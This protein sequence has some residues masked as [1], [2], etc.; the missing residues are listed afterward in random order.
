MGR[1]LGFTA[2]TIVCSTTA[3]LGQPGMPTPMEGRYD[4]DLSET[5]QLDRAQSAVNKQ[6]EQVKAYVADRQWNEAVDALIHLM[7]NSGNKLYGVTDKRYVSVREYCHLQLA[8]LP[9]EARMIYR[10]R[11]DA[12]AKKWYE[13]GAALHDGRRLMDVVDRAFTSSWGDKALRALGD[14]ALESGDYA[15]A[16]SCWE[17]IFPVEPPKEAPR[18]WLSTPDTDLDLAGLRARLVLVSILEGSLDRA[19][20]DLAAFARLHPDARGRLAG[21]ECNYA[22][23]LKAILD[24][25]KSWPSPPVDPNWPTFA[26]SPQRNKIAPGV[27]DVG[28][29]AWRV[30]LAPA[31]PLHPSG[32]R[33]PPVSLPTTPRRRSPTIL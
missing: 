16:R 18:T 8:S 31:P 22:A 3:V 5:I 7:E 4:Y 2:I 13:E 1:F 17:R 11:V 10:N 25:S 12:Q 28:E 33:L 24:E 19:R 9:S 20:E 6:F 14:M 15:A 30:P 27:V 32:P 26:G 29:V 21:R 23:A